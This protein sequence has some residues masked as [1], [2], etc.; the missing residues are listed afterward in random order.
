MIEGKPSANKM[1]SYSKPN[2][3]NMVK[4]YGRVFSETCKIAVRR[5]SFWYVCIVLASTE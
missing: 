2:D 4:K 3:T 5:R 1:Y